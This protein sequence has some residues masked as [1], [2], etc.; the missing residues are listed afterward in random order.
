MSR[1]RFVLRNG[2]LVPIEEAP[3]L[4]RHGTRLGEGPMI[5]SDIDAYR[6]VMTGEMITGRRQHREHL[7]THGVVERG[8]EPIKP[9]KQAAL[10]P[11]RHDIMRAIEEAPTK[12][13][14]ILKKSEQA[15]Y[16]G[17][18]QRIYN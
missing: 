7:K 10:P 12:S 11:V 15:A 6:S 18:P 8:N 14:E 5:M 3:P 2:E 4:V 9:S 17:K 16:L 13:K 1:G